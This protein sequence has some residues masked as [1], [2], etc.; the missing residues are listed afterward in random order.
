[1]SDE[2]LKT[3]WINR[4]AREKKAHKPFREQAS[5]AVEAYRDENDFSNERRSKALFP[6]WWSTAQITHAAVFAKPPKPDVRKRN[7]TES[8]SD[9][10][11]AQAVERALTYTIDTTGFIDHGHKIVDDF[12]VAALGTAR[13]ELDT[14]TGM[15]PV[16]DP[17]SGEPMMGPDG[18][19]I[20]QKVVLKQSVRLKHFPWNKF[21]W[22]PGSDWESCDWIAYVHDLSA[23]EIKDQFGKE[24]EGYADSSTDPKSASLSPRNNYK[25]TFEVFEIWDRKK[26]RVLYVTDD[27][28]VPLGMEDDPLGLEEFFPGPKPC[29]LNLATDKLI[30]K[31]DFCFVEAQCD[32]INELTGRIHSLTKQIKDVG[33]YDMQL[34]ELAQLSTASDGDRIPIKNLMERLNKATRGDFDQV[35]AVQDNTGKVNVLR[36]LIAQRDIEK[37]VV[38]ETLGI[39]D[40]IRG[41]TVASETAEAQKIKSQWGNV[42]IGPKISSIAIFFRDVFRLMAEVICEHFEPEQINRMSGM[43]LSAEEIQTLKDDLSRCYAIDVETDSTIAADDSEERQQRLD[44]VKAMTDYLNVYLPMAQQ[45]LI[46]AEVVK[47]TLAFVVGSFKHGRELMDAINSLPDGVAQLQQLQQQGQ[48]MQQQLEQAQQQVDQLSK[49]LEQANTQELEIKK[50]EL[51][52]N[53]I[54]AK[55]LADL[56]GAQKIEVLASAAEKS[57]HAKQANMQG[58]AESSV[59]EAAQVASQ[60]TQVAAMQMGDTVQQLMAILPALQ[61][62]VAQ[63]AQPKPKRAK[64][65]R[66]DDGSHTVDVMETMQ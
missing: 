32:S 21:R 38:F 37:Q 29:F 16:I 4:L 18:Q 66:N 13:I 23:E 33:F 7:S 64:I 9:D 6:I 40:I 26:R 35:L 41:S 36:E 54:E 53:M 50:G 47:E 62:L 61:Q 39:S 22:E 25:E 57:A 19:P 27:Y 5:K 10:R 43:E 51:D 55:S 52:A 2:S 24:V 20:L 14:K 12:I 1:M 45:N 58:D 44:M 15:A 34:K 48:Q 49:Q 46:P 56:R 11:I 30:P 65:M 60:T 31:P 8:K 17:V 59:H 42:R 63:A 3:L 28:E